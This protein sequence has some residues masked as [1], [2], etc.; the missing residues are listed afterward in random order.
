MK[1]DRALGEFRAQEE[2]LYLWSGKQVRT[3]APGLEMVLADVYW[4]RTVQYFGG[5]RV[6]AQ[7]KNFDLLLP[8][9][10][11]TVTLDPR[12]EI[13]YRYGATFLSEGAPIGAGRP[14]D[15]IAVLERGVEAMPD[16]W[17]LRQELGFFHFFFLND[18]R[19]ASEILLEA[20]EIPGA[21]Y[22]L[23]S[24]A[25]SLLVKG[26]ERQA[27]RQIWRAMYEHAEEGPIRENARQHLARLDALDAADLVARR[28]EEY[29]RQFGVRPEALEDLRR[30]GF[31]RG[32]AVD[33]SGTPFDYD[34]TSGR[35]RLSRKSM[36]WRPE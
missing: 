12:F 9:I 3:M 32:P 35:V 24:L 23:R 36:L 6:F 22:W 10:E 21:P 11:I 30:A 1:V 7:G 14:R 33:P 4:L 15:G 18:A 29:A 13:A 25:A 19:T 31:I 20:A 27:A 28:V 5:Q 17:R 34:R 8:L 2:M 16:S 26:G